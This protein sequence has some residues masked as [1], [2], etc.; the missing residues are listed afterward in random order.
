MIRR[1][2]IFAAVL[3]VGCEIKAH[4]IHA[5]YAEA[6]YRPESGRLEVALRRAKDSRSFS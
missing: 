3:A 2:L 1:V 6:D 4:P 5:S